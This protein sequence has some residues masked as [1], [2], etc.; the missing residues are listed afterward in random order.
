MAGAFVRIENWL[1]PIERYPIDVR[2]EENS[3]SRLADE[4]ERGNPRERARGRQS[5]RRRL[6]VTRD[7]SADRAGSVMSNLCFA[8]GRNWKANI[9]RVPQRA[10]H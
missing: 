1:G 6:R 7:R 2:L 8:L 3:F 5:E 4:P 9:P 10:R